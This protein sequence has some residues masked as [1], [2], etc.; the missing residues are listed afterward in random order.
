MAIKFK[1][2]DKSTLSPTGSILEH[3][4]FGFALYMNYKLL[5]FTPLAGRNDEE[6]DIILI[7]LIV[8]CSIIGTAFRWG[9]MLRFRAAIADVL[10]GIGIYTALAY[11]E[12]YGE[13]VKYVGI[14]ILFFTAIEA[15]RLSL[16]K[17][18]GQRFHELQNRELK[19]AVAKNRITKALDCGGIYAGVAA[20]VL[21][22]PIINIRYK[23]DAVA[24][25]KWDTALCDEVY[26]TRKEVAANH[27]DAF[28]KIMLWDTWN[29]LEAQKKLDVV[30]ELCACE[31]E[32]WGMREA[33]KAVVDDLGEGVVGAYIPD[34]KVVAINKGSLE[35]TD[36]AMILETVMHEMYHAWEYE[37]VELYK[38]T[39]HEQRNMR[40]F[41][42]CATYLMEM[43]DYKTAGD[44]I[45][46]QKEYYFQKMEEDSRTNSEIALNEYC[47]AFMD[48][49]Y[50]RK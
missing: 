7:A 12:Y 10:T 36:P 40:V 6:S 47:E 41:Q 39:S 42:P 38:N 14:S 27:I 32:Y 44:D 37:L 4:A 31:A 17:V 19:R 25:A 28:E 2:R 5:L 33:P 43:Q 48:I 34:R 20:I 8:I 1:V 15:V 9:K 46:S 11:G 22:I 21:L 29:T 26:P 13:V 18:Q 35:E 45:E 30:Q 50:L 23:Y 49:Y 24:V 16:E 3:L